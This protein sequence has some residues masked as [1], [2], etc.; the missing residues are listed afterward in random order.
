MDAS[1]GDVTTTRAGTEALL[2]AVGD[3]LQWAPIAS[4]SIPRALLAV[5]EEEAARARAAAV[6][7]PL[8]CVNA[9]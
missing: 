5:G 1:L 2:T 3:R 4:A 9:Y 7:G 6:L 8:G